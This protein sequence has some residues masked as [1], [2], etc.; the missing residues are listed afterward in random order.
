MVGY[1]SAG[2]GIGKER[3]DKGQV[4][5]GQGLRTEQGTRQGTGLG[6]HYLRGRGW[7]GL[8]PLDSRSRVCRCHCK[9]RQQC[10]CQ[11]L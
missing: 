2:Q 7:V 3:K 8:M 9:C 10:Q 5:A 4:R 1:L 6:S 11:T